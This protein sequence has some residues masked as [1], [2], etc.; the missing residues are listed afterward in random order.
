M[1]SPRAKKQ[2]TFDDRYSGFLPSLNE[3]ISRIKMSDIDKHEFFNEF[4]RL[5]KPV[6]IE[7]LLEEVSKLEWSISDLKQFPSNPILRIE[8]RSSC[9]NSRFGL[10]N[11]EFMTWQEFLDDISN[12]GTSLYLTTQELKF[13]NESQDL[14][15]IVSD[16][17]KHLFKCF[18]LL[19]PIY[20]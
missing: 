9:K 17:I 19:F 10:G 4:I 20:E 5:R 6:V 7:G 15:E 1:K 14:P 13:L 8:R 12:G 18:H 11:E 2:K 3:S 16:P